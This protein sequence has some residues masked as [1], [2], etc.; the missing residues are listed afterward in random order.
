MGHFC[1][2]ELKKGRVL[3]K[4]NKVQKC[5]LTFILVLVQVR[6]LHKTGGRAQQLCRGE[7]MYMYKK[8]ENS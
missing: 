2:Q 5:I 4:K 6:K 7:A 1:V 3:D 8:N